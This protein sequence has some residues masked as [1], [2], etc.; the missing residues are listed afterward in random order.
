MTAILMS[1]LVGCYTESEYAR[2][3]W[4][5]DCERR[6]ECYSDASLD[7]LPYDDVDGCL[8]HNAASVEDT[9]VETT[10]QDCLFDGQAAQDCVDEVATASCDEFLDGAFLET[11]AA[12]CA[13]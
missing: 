8:E 2:D 6:L 10:A 7:A 13:E 3:L 1:L 11:C 12:V 4:T 5:A 9:R